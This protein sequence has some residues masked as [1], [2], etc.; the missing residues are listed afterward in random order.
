[1][2]KAVQNIWKNYFLAAEA[3]FFLTIGDD[4]MSAPLALLPNEH[5]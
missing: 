5:G 2:N 4:L 1:M 3:F